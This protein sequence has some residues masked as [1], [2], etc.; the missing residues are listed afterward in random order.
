MSDTAADFA[1]KGRRGNHSRL[2]GYPQCCNEPQICKYVG[3]LCP[4]IAFKARRDDHWAA[5][6]RCVVCGGC[7]GVVRHI[8]IHPEYHPFTEA[9]SA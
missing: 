6:P 1:H 9:Q 4:F 3:P 7:E 2:S 8:S 5:L